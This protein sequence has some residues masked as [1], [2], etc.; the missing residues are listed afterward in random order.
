MNK[1]VPHIWLSYVSYPITTAAYLERALRKTCRV[2][3]IGPTLPEGLITKWNLDNLTQPILPH[4]IDTSM[5][6]D[7]GDILA[8]L[9]PSD[10]PDLFLWVES[11]DSYQP[12]NLE[13]FKCP[14]IGYLI[15]THLSIDSHRKLATLF[16]S[17][18]MVHRQ[19]VEEIR[20]INPNTYWSPVA[21]DPEIHRSRGDGKRFDIGF[22]GSVRPGSRREQLLC[23]LASEFQ[24]H[25]ERCFLN[26]MADV[27]SSSKMVFNEALRNDLNMRVFEVLST[28]SLLL[29]DMTSNTGQD[30]LFRDGEDFALY[31]DANITDVARFYMDNE[32]LREQ[33]A[34]RGQR[35]VHNAHTYDHRVADMLAVALGGKPD[36]FS[37]EELREQ[38]LA[39]MP[40]ID[41]DI[42][43]NICISS[44]RRSF[45][46]PVLDMSPASEYNILTLLKDLE[47]IEGDV[48]VIFNGQEV[49][50][51]LKNHPRITRYAVLKQN[52]GVARAWNLGLEIAVTPTVFILNADLHVERHAIDALEAA[53]YELPA[54]ACVG[55]QGSF[56][57]Y[58]LARDY[59][60]F[61]KGT[62]SEPLEVDAVSGFFFAIRLQDF[63]DKILRFENGFTPCY[64]EEWDLGLQ[65]KRAGLKNYIVPTSAYDHHWSGTIS[66]LREINFYEKAETAG[67]ILLRNR[68]LFLTKWRGITS[69]E[70]SRDLL[71]SGFLRFAVSHAQNMAA[72]GRFD[73]IRK[74][75][76]YVAQRCRDD[77]EMAALR[78]FVDVMASKTGE[79]LRTM[80]EGATK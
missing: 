34:T 77:A 41:A 9:D 40:A 17:V 28:G 32:G 10:H 60:H 21:C 53:L 68:R 22:V 45:V 26:E 6:P 20:K 23:R 54:A 4:D 74:W 30:I 76:D 51:H 31:Q 52:I 62:F 65:I 27:F 59:I 71:E 61:D 64:F 75:L 67:E 33:I 1:A 70:N 25:Y 11:V 47:G 79:P 18:F 19:H 14:K 50:D 73:D 38:S 57:E 12:R 69:R 48:I 8:Q 7:M 58:A 35:L 2:T 63:N 72:E 3:T 49:A 46:I 42:P 44:A 39:G 29:T 78:R 80:T 37:A 24:I 15:D 55:P 13:A 66:A 43:A 36:T 5:S 56:V 16:D